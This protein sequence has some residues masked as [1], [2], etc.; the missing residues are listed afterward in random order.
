MFEHVSSELKSLNIQESEL[1]AELEQ[2]R[3]Q[4]DS[5]RRELLREGAARDT[6]HGIELLSEFDDTLLSRILS[7]ISAVS[8]ST[9]SVTFCGG[10]TVTQSIQA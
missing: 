7:G 6:L 8:S 10:Y 2:L 3:T 5:F 1:A 9:I 4:H